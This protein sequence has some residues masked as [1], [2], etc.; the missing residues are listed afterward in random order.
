MLSPF[1]VDATREKGYFAENTLAGSRMRTNLSDLAASISVINKQQM[2]DT[3]SVDVNDLFRYE[4]NTEGATTYTP[5]AASSRGDGVMDP[6]A[7]AANPSTG[8]FSTVSTANRVRGL[9]TPSFAINY[10]PSVA[11][12]PMDSYNVESVEISRGPNSMLF[13]MGNPAGIVNQTTASAN[14]RKNSARVTIRFDNLGSHRETLSFNRV[15][16]HDK[17]AIYGAL[18]NDEREFRRKPSYDDTRRYYGAV[19]YK[20]FSKTTIRV[21]AESYKNKN[22]RPNSLTPLDGISQWVKAG[23]PVYDALNKTISLNN[24]QVIGPYILNASSPRA[25]EVRDYIQSRPD[26]DST[27][28]NA[29]ANTYNGVSIFGEA[30]LTNIA[31]ILYVPGITWW[32][33]GTRV[34]QNYGG[35]T[36]GMYQPLGNQQYRTAWGT[37]TNPTATAPAYPDLAD[38]W[39]NSVWADVFN[40]YTAASN[41][42]TQ[43]KNSLIGSYKYPGVTDQSIYDWEK[44]NILAA[45]SG[46]D[47]NKTYNI[48]LEQQLLDNLFFSAGYFRQDFKSD[49]NYVIGQI[50]AATLVVDVSRYLPDGTPNPFLGKPFVHAGGASDR[51]INTEKSDHYR[52]M[53]A[54]TPDFTR[55]DGWM[56]WLGSHQILGMWSRQDTMRSSARMRPVFT[57]AG[58]DSGKYRYLANQNNNADG[59]PTGWNYQTDAIRPLFYLAGPDD[60]SGKVTS[61]SAFTSYAYNGDIRVYDYATNSFQDLPLT[62]DYIPWDSPVRNHRVIDSL[63]GAMTSYF[64]KDRFVATFGVRRD[65]YKGRR[66]TTGAILNDAGETVISGMTNAQ[67]WV[68]GV[69]QT[70]VIDNRWQRWDR[71]SGTTSTLGGVLKPF[72]NWESIESRARHSLFWEFVNDFG[73]SYNQSDNFNAPDSTQ[74]DSFG[75]PLPKPTGEGKDYGIQFALFKNKLFARLTLFEAKNINERYAPGTSMSRFNTNV[76]Q[77]LFRLWARTISLINMGQDPTSS[78][79]GAGLSAAEET[80]VQTAAEEIWKMPYN[81]YNQI[82]S[83]YATRTAEAKGWEM[84]INFNPTPNWTMRLTATKTETVNSNVLKEFD[85]WYAV[86]RPIWEDARASDYLLPQYQNLATFTNSAGRP[87]DLTNFL[88]SYGYSNDAALDNNNGFTDVQKYYD[89]VVLPQYILLSDLNGQIAPGQRKYRGAFITNYLFDTG[90]L[91][92]FSVGGGL[93]WED[94][95]VIGYYGRS[96]GASG[97]GVLDASDI[98]RPIHDKANFYTDFWLAYTTRIFNNKYRMKVQLNIN[99]IFEDGGLRTVGVNYDGSPYAFRIVDPRQFILSV[100]LDF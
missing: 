47:H 52:A 41:P 82:G 100:A 3:A 69:L 48:E 29:A 44:V 91:K 76:D 77:N 92:G 90:K 20:P 56:K 23:E 34:L 81:Y 36:V 49:A 13:G 64:W 84:Q 88:T 53:L 28:W 16:V 1:Q 93:R 39:T 33:Q 89:G 5:M 37:D 12:V 51:Y 66:T 31:S 10:Y 25:Q 38:I 63:S 8:A 26:F 61:A 43:Q 99:D 71:L 74:V 72:K 65:K 21:N 86:R 32:G 83:V 98:S 35:Q 9:G 22:R 14:V 94:K 17:L 70:D 59:T 54:Y 42:W 73:F 97:A 46:I 7:G 78:S 85:A 95:A 58:T 6:N 11:Q 27:K 75:T 62:M 24:G 50:N 2:E 96:T 30:A 67:K 60:P 57:G 45:N 4:L 15:L 68:N 55:Y 19:T 79:F 80:A 18:V 40:R 87:N